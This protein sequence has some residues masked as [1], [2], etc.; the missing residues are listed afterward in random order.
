MKAN[1]SDTIKSM[2]AKARDKIDTA[3]IMLENGKFDD[4]VSRSYY[5]VFHTISAALYSKGLSFST[6]SQVIGAFNRE[7]VK[8]G[9]FPPSFTKMI[10]LMFNERQTGD[11]DFDSWIDEQT[12]RESLENAET[13][14]AGIE[15]YLGAN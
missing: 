2:L 4:V 8:N 6:H 11:Y 15:K 7:F 10:K 1:Q 14:V 12:A 5:A 3:R 13:I 9:V